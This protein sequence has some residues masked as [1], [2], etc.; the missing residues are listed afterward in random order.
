[1]P[2]TAAPPATPR[3]PFSRLTAVDGLAARAV[4]PGEVPTLDHEVGDDSVKRRPS[5][6]QVLARRADALLPRAQG[7]EVFDGLGDGV[8]VKAHDDAA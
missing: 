4:A 3:H 1:M 7:P 5:V 6:R 2:P 8:A